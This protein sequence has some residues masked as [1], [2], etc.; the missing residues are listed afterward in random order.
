MVHRKYGAFV[1][2]GQLEKGATLRANLDAWLRAM[3]LSKRSCVRHVGIH[4]ASQ[5]KSRDDNSPLPS[6]E[7]KGHVWALLFHCHAPKDSE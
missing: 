4:A 1:R 5:E 3:S 2:A 6:A 7:Q